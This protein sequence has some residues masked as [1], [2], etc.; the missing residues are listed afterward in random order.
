MLYITCFWESSNKTPTQRR[1]T[2]TGTNLSLLKK[3]NSKIKELQTIRELYF[4]LSDKVKTKEQQ[5]RS[6]KIFFKKKTS[7]KCPKVNFINLKKK[8]SMISG[9]IEEK[10]LVPVGN[11]VL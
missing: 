5:Y 10:Q 11:A 1:P 4:I 2:A 8:K 7:N 3:Q 9:E 6:S